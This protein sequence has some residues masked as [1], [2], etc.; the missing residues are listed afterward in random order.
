[1]LTIEYCQ[2]NN[3]QCKYAEESCSIPYR[4]RYNK[5]RQDSTQTYW[6]VPDETILE[7]HLKGH[8]TG[9]TF[10]DDEIVNTIMKFENER[11]PL[12][13][14]DR[15]YKIDYYQEY[16]YVYKNIETDLVRLYTEM[17]D[18]IKLHLTPSIGLIEFVKFCDLLKSKIFYL[19]NNT[20]LFYIEHSVKND[21]IELCAWNSY[22]RTEKLCVIAK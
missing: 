7:L 15:V 17:Q 22:Y 16:I 8:N 18:F 11:T 3:I 10:I 1:M 5:Y 19:D 4:K 20:K 6:T 12:Y 21:T 14:N 2:F 9:V 13:I